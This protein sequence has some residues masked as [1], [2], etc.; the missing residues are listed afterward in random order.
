MS[1][2]NHNCLRIRIKALSILYYFFSDIDSRKEKIMNVLLMNKQNFEKYFT[3]FLSDPEVDSEMS[4]KANFILYQL[5]RLQ[6]NL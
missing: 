4:E 1:L 3:K 6:N 5:E 2:L